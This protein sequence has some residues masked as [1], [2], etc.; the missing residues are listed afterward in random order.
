M[1]AV[2][3]THQNLVPDLLRGEGRD[4]GKGAHS[5]VLQTGVVQS[6]WRTLSR[7]AIAPSVSISSSGVLSGPA[8]A[9]RPPIDLDQRDDLDGR[10]A[11]ERLVADVE[12]GAVDAALDDRLAEFLGDQLD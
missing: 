8:A 7:R 12:L 4:I 5:S 9:D 2:N 11:Q 1:L 3:G 6:R 10:T